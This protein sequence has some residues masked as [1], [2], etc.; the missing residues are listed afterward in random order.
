MT[1]VTR[2]TRLIHSESDTYPVYLSNMA[3]YA[4]NTMYGATV[5]SDLLIEFGLEVVHDTEIPTGDVV[6]EGR[7]ELISG[8][9][10][11]TWV[12][13]SYS[14]V[15]AATRLATAK[16]T[17]QAQAETMRV[18]QFDRG[19]P[20]TFGENVYH[21]QIRNADRSNLLGLRTVAKEVVAAG[22]D[23]TFEFRVYENVV[24][25][26]SAAEMVAV[27][28]AAFTAA[29]LGYRKTWAVKDGADLATT[30]EELPPLTT[31]EDFFVA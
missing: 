13:R 7:P 10:Y 26:I 17:L 19:F 5:D 25:E 27:A 8:E 30:I 31:E 18:T 3:M 12:V 24:V 2:L 20:H 1:E 4:P 21:V 29:T 15:E 11:Q 22:G 9:W 23:M 14:E 16:T 28:D 6:T